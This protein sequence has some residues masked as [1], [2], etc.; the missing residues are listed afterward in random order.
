MQPETEFDPWTQT[1]SLAPRRTSHL[2]VTETTA[3]RPLD[4]RFDP[5]G[6]Q[7]L[8]A[9]LFDPLFGPSS[10]Q[11]AGAL[12]TYAVLDAAK[13]PG[14]AEILDTSGLPHC[15][16]FT[17]KTF[18]ELKDA[19]P[20][21]VELKA[22]HPFTADLLTRSDAPWHLW[23]ASAGIYLR[24][25]RDLK[26]VGQHLRK[27]TR[28]RD[29]TGKW[30]YFRFWEP[31]VYAF[32]CDSMPKPAL[33]MERFFAQDV[34]AKTIVLAKNTAKITTRSGTDTAQK[35]AISLD[36][37]LLE[38]LRDYAAFQNIC[39]IT[40]QHAALHR[41]EFAFKGY[42]NI[43]ENNQFICAHALYIGASSKVEVSS[44]CYLALWL[45]RDF[46]QDPLHRWAQIGLDEPGP[47]ARTLYWQDKIFSYFDDVLGPDGTVLA[48][49]AGRALERMDRF[50]HG[51]IP[52]S[53]NQC[54]AIMTAVYP[55]KVAFA[56]PDNTRNLARLIEI[57]YRFPGHG[58]KY[59]AAFCCLFFGIGFLHDPIS[60]F[61]GRDFA[62]SSPVDLHARARRLLTLR[63]KPPRRPERNA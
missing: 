28:L 56:G 29:E 50:V 61:R 49:A 7:S 57:E 16:L 47:K 2:P 10:T 45:G 8:P 13:V 37:H 42:H 15:C 33:F 54:L 39:T 59:F 41:R 60:P 19:A 58:D 24:S 43:L 11:H 22:A 55:E 1:T 31:G 51:H 35:P 9:P 48:R 44:L 46:L 63:S 14:L 40:D 4:A 12:K 6:E 5:H 17:G 34:L 38:V 21:L 23:D 62:K 52:Y 25:E 27:F 32:I 18:D 30:Y 53:I 20:W 3:I 26:E 36:E